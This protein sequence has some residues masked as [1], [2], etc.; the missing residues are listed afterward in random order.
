[1]SFCVNYDTT[2]EAALQQKLVQT[3]F[4]PPPSYALNWA[5]HTR[6]REREL[7]RDEPTSTAR[8]SALMKFL[9]KK[10]SHVPLPTSQRYSRHG[11]SQLLFGILPTF[12]FAQHNAQYLRVPR[13]K[14][15]FSNMDMAN[16][17]IVGNT[18]L[19]FNGRICSLRFE[20][21]TAVTMKN[22]VF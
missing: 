8:R 9:E 11:I 19:L 20:V 17:L 16:I 13:A 5:L 18:D 10:W 2:V 4:F 1:V 22:A 12:H 15:I 21:F 14:C 6:D 3:H 7:R